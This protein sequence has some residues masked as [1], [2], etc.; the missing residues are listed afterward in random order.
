M[1]QQKM[2][3]LILKSINTLGLVKGLQVSLKLLRA[4]NETQ[5]EMPGYRF[6]I[7]TRG[8]TSDVETFE[9]IF[10]S[11][12]YDYCVGQPKLILDLGANVGY[13][14]LFF[15]NKY[16]GCKII[17][18]EPEASN[19]AMLV[20][21]V[22]NYPNVVPVHAAIWSKNTSLRI[23][24]PEGEKW[25]FQVEETDE[26]D[27]FAA[28]TIDDLLALEP[29]A[30][31]SSNGANGRSQQIDILK[32]DIESAEKELFAANYQSWLDKVNLL[33]IELHDNLRP[34]CSKSVYQALSHYC[35]NQFVVGEN[36]FV[37]LG[38]ERNL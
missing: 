36:I 10:I 17:S 25:L 31:R 1:T 27:G 22:Q 7:L 26:A 34:G 38:N 21:N 4:E 19:Y 8:K 29:V 12:E 14:A 24:N 18:V 30:G 6:P 2:L 3:R 15:A 5:V 13:A 11:K 33:I 9:Q 37:L 28:V 20:R 35:F 16:P 32:I 23:V